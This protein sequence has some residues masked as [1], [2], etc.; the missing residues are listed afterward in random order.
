MYS[1]LRQFP[2]LI[3][4][5]PPKTPTHQR[6]KSTG[7]PTFSVPLPSSHM[8]QL[9]VPKPFSL[10]QGLALAALSL[11]PPAHAPMAVFSPVVL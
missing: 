8:R 4:E 3:H 2:D 6:G 7:P 1:G 10:G 9:A 11:C 5:A